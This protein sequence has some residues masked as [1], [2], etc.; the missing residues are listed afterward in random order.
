MFNL[1]TTTSDVDIRVYIFLETMAQ[2]ENLRPEEMV[3]MENCYLELL[4]NACYPF[5][6]FPNIVFEFDSDENVRKNYAGS[7]FY[8]LR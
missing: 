2:R 7:Y 6:K 8:R 5:D 1:L 3:E 4:R